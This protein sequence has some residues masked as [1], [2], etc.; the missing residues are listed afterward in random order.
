[1]W[2][3][4]H[5]LSFWIHISEFIRSH[6]VLSIKWVLGQSPIVTRWW[7]QHKSINICSQPSETTSY[8]VQSE[9]RI[10]SLL[11]FQTIAKKRHF[12]SRMYSYTDTQVW[13]YFLFAHLELF[14]FWHEDFCEDNQI[15]WLEIPLCTISYRIR[16]V[17]V[18]I[19][20]L[21]FWLRSLF[22]WI[23]FSTYVENVFLEF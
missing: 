8:V 9:S 18:R 7:A 2:I 14:I 6:I 10:H 15:K 5:I 1:M 21:W 13:Y 23:R 17:E 19:L 16:K 22:N 4:W 12:C 11:S 3:Q 20:V